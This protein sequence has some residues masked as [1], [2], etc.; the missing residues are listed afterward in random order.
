MIT[1]E[2][3]AQYETKVP[4]PVMGAEPTPRELIRHVEW[5]DTRWH[6]FKE[7]GYGGSNE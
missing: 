5:L 7:A 3:I 4:E 6:Y 2:M 1:A